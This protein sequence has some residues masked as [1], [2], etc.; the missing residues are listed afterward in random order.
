MAIVNCTLPLCF[1]KVDSIYL[2]IFGR[3]K[4]MKEIQS[5]AARNPFS[6]SNYDM[7]YG[8]APVS[9]FGNEGDDVEMVRL[10]VRVKV[11]VRG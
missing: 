8:Y 7:G 5:R 2:S 6:S 1:S 9:T 10:S 4:V 3:Q 11:R